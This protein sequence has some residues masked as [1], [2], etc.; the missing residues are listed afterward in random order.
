MDKRG[1]GANPMK[2]QRRQRLQFVSFRE[3]KLYLCSMYLV[4]HFGPNIEDSKTIKPS[5][6]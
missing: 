4:D 2:S 6:Y 1:N 3:K 5:C